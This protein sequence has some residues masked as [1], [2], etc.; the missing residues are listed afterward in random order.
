MFVLLI[1]GCADETAGPSCRIVE[2]ETTLGT[3]RVEL[4]P[5]RAPVTVGNF[6]QYVDSGF[7]DGTIFH[8]VVPG[9]VIRGGGFTREMTAR[10]AMR[11]PIP[12]ETPNGLRNV[13]GTIAMARPSQPNSATTQF[14]INLTDNR[15]FDYIP[16]VSQ[17]NGY[18]VFGRVIQGMDVVDSIAHVPTHTE[19]GHPD[20][21]VVPVELRI[22][23]FSR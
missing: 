4:D 6:L 12:L 7:Y 8:G 20:V 2:I 23:R 22:V 14:F 17:P 21:P 18:A 3:I 19:Q 16:S 10:P 5:E 9:F 15:V 13:R 1:T 11:P